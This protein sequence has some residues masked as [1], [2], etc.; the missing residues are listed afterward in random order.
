MLLLTY[1]RTPGA[2][3]NVPRYGNCRKNPIMYGKKSLFLDVGNKRFR[4]QETAFSRAF[5]CSFF[6]LLALFPPSLSS[7]THSSLDACY[8]NKLTAPRLCKRSP[9]F[10][11]LMSTR[12][13]PSVKAE[14]PRIF[15]FCAR[16]ERKRLGPRRHGSDAIESS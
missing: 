1:C 12:I 5:A 2:L 10:G 4:M 15:C 13:M 11:H 7:S 8:P 9:S 3:S 14:V 6:S 16:K